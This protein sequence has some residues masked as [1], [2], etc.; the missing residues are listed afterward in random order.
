VL[1]QALVEIK[2]YW[3]HRDGA[4][5]NDLSPLVERGDHALGIAAG[6]NAAAFDS[7]SFMV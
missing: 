6:L 2:D 5:L 1:P 4:A 7:I 3:F